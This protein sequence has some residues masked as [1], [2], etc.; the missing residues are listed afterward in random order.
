MK[1]NILIALWALL[2][3]VSCNRSG[4]DPEES[5]SAL[6]DENIFWDV[7]GK[8]V[9]YRDITPDYQGKTFTAVIGS[10]EG[11]DASIRV[12]GVNDPGAAASRFNSLTGAEITETTASYTYQ[13]KQVGTLTWN[14]TTDNTSWATVDVNIPAVPGLKKIIYR[15]AEQG[16]VNSDVGNGGSAYY[17]FGDVLKKTRAEDNITEYWICVRPAFGPEDKGNSHWVC[18]SPLPEKNIWPYNSTNSQQHGHPWKA[19][20]DMYYGLPDGIRDELEWHQDLAEMLFAIMFPDIWST[21]VTN[22]YTENMFGRPN[23][24]R[25]FNDF[26]GY[27]IKF[28]NAEFWKNVQ[29]EWKDRDLVQKIFG[30][31]YAEMEA[32]LNPN[33]PGSRGLHLLYYGK[34]WNTTTSNKPKL[35]QVHYTNGAETSEKNMHLQ[36]K[37]KPTAQVVTPNKKDGETATNFPMDVKLETSQARPYWINR[38]FFGDEIPR[39]IVR[40]ATGEE[41]SDTRNYDPQQPI[42]G[43]PVASEVYRYYEHVLHG[44]H[45]LLDPPEVTLAESTVQNDVSKQDH[46]PFMKDGHYAFGDVLR[47]ANGHHWFVVRPA[48]GSKD[49]NALTE[50]SPFAE[51]VSFEGITFSDDGAVATNLPDKERMLRVAFPLW[52]LFQELVKH[53]SGY[54]QTPAQTIREHAGVDLLHLMQE[55]LI[56]RYNGTVGSCAEVCS[57]AYSV[58]GSEKQHLMR[59]I[60]ETRDPG[61]AFVAVAYGHYPTDGTQENVYPG[62]KANG[63]S[64]I[65]IYLQDVADADKVAKYGPDYMAA[66]PFNNTAQARA[67]RQETDA[68][69]LNPVNYLYNQQTWASAQTKPLGM[70]NEPVLFFRATALYDR[71]SVYATRTVDG[72]DLIFETAGGI[73]PDWEEKNPHEWFFSALVYNNAEDRVIDGLNAA[74]P[75]WQK[76][77]ATN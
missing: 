61:N 23:G 16:D 52:F 46:S 47:D 18:V 1:K 21:N 19:S 35:F 2:C 31:S 50:Q 66:R 71:G 73:T 30:V 43:F 17:R 75:A 26:S 68:R 41:L 8:L 11:G 5:G 64:D 32:D 12:V 38:K 33:R 48:G 13:S 15:S 63:F 25:M 7:V 34:D 4:L 59:Y 55:L 51:L 29:K 9:D 54:V 56:T 44:Q 28:H 27:N 72:Q 10:P 42:P 69:A 37:T 58:P 67:C 22:Y 74:L 6:S 14:L 24:L 65:P 62:I 53:P 70:W 20:N 36:T 40:Y 45:N 3:L 77:W 76:I 49:D 57:I 60:V 39:W